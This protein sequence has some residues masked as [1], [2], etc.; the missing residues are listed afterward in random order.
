MMNGTFL[1]QWRILPFRRSAMAKGNGG[2]SGGQHAGGSQGGGT[3]GA[4]SAG[5]GKGGG[6]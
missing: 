3:H 2:G 5:G 6:K 4:G 1:F